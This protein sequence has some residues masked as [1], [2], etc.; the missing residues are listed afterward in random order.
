MDTT[1]GAV[2]ERKVLHGGP[3]RLVRRQKPSTDAGHFSGGAASAVARTELAHVPEWAGSFAGRHMDH[4]YYELVEDT[5]EPAFSYRYF[6]IRDRSGKCAAVQPF[7]VMDVDL[8]TAAGAS[9]LHFASIVRRFWPRFMLVR[10]LMV[11]CSGGP[12]ALG[13]K[14]EQTRRQCAEQLLD[15]ALSEARRT[16]A[17]QVV[18]KEFRKQDRSALRCFLDR[19]F[20]RIPSLP[21]SSV[22]I[23]HASFE[24]YA[25]SSLGR[26]TR[27]N[28]RRK[29]KAAARRAP[30]ELSVLTY[31]GE[32]VDELYPLYLQ[33]YERS[34]L[35]FEKLTKEFLVELGR[36]MPD[37]VRFF[38]W[39]QNGRAVAFS[40][41][42]VAGDTIYDEY[43]GLDYSIAFELHLYH[44]SYRDILAW[45]MKNGYKRY[46][47]M[48]VSYRPKLHLG[49]RLEPLDLYVRHSSPLINAVFRLFLPLVGP[50]SRDK[51]LARFA[52]YKE[53]WG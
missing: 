8:L 28:L 13:G 39:R 36:R 21:M 50:V 7:F 14:D 25:K 34:H 52:N 3:W 27:K 20:L 37:R 12:G 2:P 43:I 29:F 24:E 10:S 40:I 51:T 53:L 19:G 32:I 47:S 41:C 16:A 18:L 35:R 45:A 42:L 22:G 17:R 23:C 48:G 44:L 4:R 26:A 15:A 46:V 33:V 49:H 31:V 11:G 9:W 30:I 1:S 38:V 6:V 5:I